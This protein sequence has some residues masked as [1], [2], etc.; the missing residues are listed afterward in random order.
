[1]DV[2]RF[3]ELKLTGWS[4]AQ[5]VKYRRVEVPALLAC[6]DVA[7]AV[8]VGTDVDDAGGTVRDTK[9]LFEQCDAT[10]RHVEE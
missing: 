7:Q 2:E 4:A 8:E 5:V 3:R 10:V 1:M 6:G 9:T